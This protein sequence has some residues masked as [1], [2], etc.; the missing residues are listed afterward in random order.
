MIKHYFKIAV[1]SLG[2]QKVLS[3]INISGLSIGLACFILFLLYAVNEFSFDR[4]H[5]NAN[6][7]YRVYRWK[8]AAKGEDASGDVYMPSPLGIAMKQDLPDIA[9]YTRFQEGWGS[10]FAKVDDKIVRLSLSFADPDFFSMFSFNFIHGNQ[11]SALKNLQDIII[12]RKKA[13]ELF[14][15]ENVLGRTIDIKMADN[16][17]PFTIA[18][19]TEDIPANSSIRFELMGNFNYWETTPS[20]KRGINNWFRS[21]YLTYV[22]LNP[23]SGLPGD[24]KKLV[25]FRHKYY[26][27]EEAEL[28]KAGYTWKGFDLPVRYGLQTG[29]H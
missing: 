6:D 8:A 9:R 21:S 23:G 27:E 28:K 13:I 17:T 7:I 14:G 15:S 19:V 20:G 16:F 1:R 25:G 26:P 4:F 24:I 12:T 29:T 10:S 11:H 5:K 22:Q 2:R 3:F 18:G